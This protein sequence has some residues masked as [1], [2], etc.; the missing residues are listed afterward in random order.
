MSEQNRGTVSLFFNNNEQIFQWTSVSLRTSFIDPLGSMLIQTQPLPDSTS[1]YRENLKKG[2][3]VGFKINGIKQEVMLIVSNRQ[4]VGR[5]GFSMSV[6][7]R[8]VLATAF[9]GSV[10][11]YI[12][13]SFDA[14]TPVS[15]AV[16]EALSPYGFEQLQ[17]DAASY[18]S[19]LTGKGLKGQQ[20][21][22]IV[23]ALKHKDVQASPSEKAYAFCSRIFSRLGCV[24]HVK[25]D[26]TILLT[27][28]DYSQ[29]P[30]Y[31]LI[32]G[33]A[34][35]LDFDRVLLEPAVEVVD[36]NEGQFSEIIIIGKEADKKGQK[37]ATAPTTGVQVEGAGRPPSAPFQA[38]SLET[39]PRGRH[40][41]L[42]EGGATY[43]PLFVFDKRARD[44]ERARN[45][46]HI[47][48]G[49]KAVRAYQIMCSVDGLI[50]NTGAIWTTGTVT[51]FISETLDIDENFFILET[52]KTIDASGQRT[53]L[54][55]IPLNSLILGG[56]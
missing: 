5:D 33:S 52:T 51:R 35:R 34:L 56:D 29:S 20:A 30:A 46:A 49:S 1:D 8:S 50:S 54:V 7:C 16:I 48:M 9:E 32:E 36:T 37:A 43:K 12:A 21:D 53:D 14:D 2:N 26:G 31:T 28:P 11:P 17:S 39:L 38:V 3:L 23:D 6:D 13:K 18:L 45:M 55:L 15:S 19:A 42:S 4:R 10:D 47:L 27:K 22:I 25:H 24:V 41:Y 40:S 44:R